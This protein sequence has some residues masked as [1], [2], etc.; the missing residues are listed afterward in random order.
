MSNSI[1]GAFNKAKEK[2]KDFVNNASSSISTKLKMNLSAS[3]PSS[4]KLSSVRSSNTNVSKGEN[5]SENIEQA[6]NSLPQKVYSVS[7]SASSDFTSIKYSEPCNTNHVYS[8]SSTCPNQI[9]CDDKLVNSTVQ[10]VN[11]SQFSSQN[12]DTLSISQLIS[13]SPNSSDLSLN[14]LTNKLLSIISQ[15][16]KLE[17]EK[18]V[19]N[20]IKVP[21]SM[22]SELHDFSSLKENFP[23]VNA[24]ADCN[25]GKS[26]I[27]TNFAVS[28][29]LKFLQCS[30]DKIDKQTLKNNNIN[31]SYSDCDSFS[32]ETKS[33]EVCPS[34]HVDSVLTIEENK[35]FILPHKEIHGDLLN[36]EKCVSENKCSLNINSNAINIDFKKEILLN[37]DKSKSKLTNIEED[38]A[39]SK[40]PLSESEKALTN[41]EVS[42]T[43]CLNKNE[44]VSPENHCTPKSVDPKFY[45]IFCH[46]ENH[47]SHFCCKFSDSRQFWQVI[48]D[49]QRCKNCFRQFHMSHKCYDKSFCLLRNCLRHDKHS[50]VLCKQRYKN[51]YLQGSQPN[52]FYPN[53]KRFPNLSHFQ[54]VNYHNFI[55]QN[56]I[57]KQSLKECFSKA[58]QTENTQFESVGVQTPESFGTTTSDINSDLQISNSISTFKENFSTTMPATIVRS[59]CFSSSSQ[60]YLFAN[61]LVT[62]IP[63]CSVISSC[64]TKM[65]A[66]LQPSLSSVDVSQQSFNDF[67]SSK[68]SLVENCNILQK[69]IHD[70]SLFR[71]CKPEELNFIKSTI[72]N[73]NYYLPFPD[74][75]QNLE[76]LRCLQTYV[77]DRLLDQSK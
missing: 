57:G 65:S 35:D 37:V 39:I 27:D 49:E 29:D 34:E 2:T 46:S 33:S 67:S 53:V 5:K 15:T 61:S 11:S 25:S 26:I 69:F 16:E 75:D 6:S 41:V 30:N 13:L 64:C 9:I 43:L 55:P 14:C 51:N 58:T 8:N 4:P 70:P 63:S 56:T 74:I 3:P 40:N 21:Y 38:I 10:H 24:K 20:E 28:N 66:S 71:N 7:S 22:L 17:E 36:K 44:P 19:L 45:C 31:L 18:V 73:S 77:A 62:N 23:P 72:I 32:I 60:T 54:H 48:Y 76:L 68:N 1:F 50:P 47:S 42:P 12:I 59:S 52:H